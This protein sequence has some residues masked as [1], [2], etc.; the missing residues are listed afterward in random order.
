MAIGSVASSQLKKKSG[1]LQRRSTNSDTI[2]S[3][4]STGVVTRSMARAA[5]ATGTKRTVAVVS[6]HSTDNTDSNMN[7]G[8]GKSLLVDPLKGKNGS[9]LK[10]KQ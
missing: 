1:S 8:V 5:A 2:S 10:M 3:N 4:Q 7:D 9:T 6:L